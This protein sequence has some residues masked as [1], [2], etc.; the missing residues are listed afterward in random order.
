MAVPVR[1]LPEL[2]CTMITFSGSANIHA[3][4]DV[5]RHDWRFSIKF[6]FEPLVRLFSDLEDVV[7]GGTVMIRPMIL[8][9]SVVEVLLLVVCRSLGRIDNP[10]LIG[11]L[12]IQVLGNLYRDK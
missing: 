1:P 8:S 5:K 6:T 4:T 9:H 2:Q 3:H 11:M 12:L 10:V 7:E